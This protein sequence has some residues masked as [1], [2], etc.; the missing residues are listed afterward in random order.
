MQFW[1][2]SL[3][4]R[5]VSYFSLLSLLTVI[6]VGVLTFLGARVL[7]T[8]LVFDRLRVSAF[9]KA[10]AIALWIENQQEATTAI[11]QLNEVRDRLPALLQ[12]PTAGDRAALD[13]AYI[14]T[15]RLLTS[16][17][18]SRPELAEIMILDQKGGRVVLSTNPEHEGEYRVKDSYFTEG[19]RNT[20]VQS[21]YPSPVTNR[22]TITISTP[23]G[24]A[25]GQVVAVLA[26][27][28]NLEQ[29]DRIV[30]ERVGLGQSGT[31]YL[32][33]AYNAFVSGDRFGKE[34][35]PRGVHSE[36]IDK[37]INQQDGGGLYLDY[38]GVPVIGYSRWV[39]EL[40]VA[41]LVEITQAE[42][43]RPAR[44]LAWGIF[45]VGSGSVLL[46]MAGVSWFSLQITRPILAIKEA[47]IRVANGD[48]RQMAPVM[49]NDEVGV[50]AQAFNQMTERLQDLYAG[51]EEKVMQLELAEMSVRKSL[52]EL[53]IEQARSERLLL[54]TL[55]QAIAKRLKVGESVIAEH[56]EQ[57][58][59][60]FADLVNFTQI[61]ERMPPKRL[62]EMLNEIFSEFDQ[63][64][65]R[66]QL[67][68]I[69]TIGDAYMVVGG[70]PEPNPYHGEAVAAM[71][72][73]MLTVLNA[74]NARTGETLNLR[75]GIHSGS[76]VAGVIGMKKF[77]YDLWGDTVNL[78]SRMESQGETG[79]IQ[80]SPVTYELI[81]S[82]FDCVPRGPIE[83]KGKGSMVTYFLEG[84]RAVFE[85]RSPSNPL[86]IRPHPDHPPLQDP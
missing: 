35:Y 83:V 70:L 49:T 34:D 50:L 74:F 51:W 10:D 80:L 26:V 72:L 6:S 33:D 12:N 82:R 75:I 81:K 62:V 56:Y 22:P 14:E 55:P 59:V 43:F 27:H 45:I 61:A 23:L 86:Q 85:E 79:R 29:M 60:L 37:A 67:E 2:K 53:E 44:Q 40:Q 5:L 57:V 28:L 25:R 24:D 13:S 21:V 73:D 17:L 76:V 36:G 11:A 69:K 47:A 42:A 54:N 1:S 65:D 52:Q 8:R 58:T 7:I 41:L 18:A 48:F 19:L 3:R 20:Y 84:D 4:I 31:S 68:K 46:V 78:A 32:V 63:L 77:T 39:D 15:K 66:H 9:L 38:A 16:T 64:S 30:T 71:A